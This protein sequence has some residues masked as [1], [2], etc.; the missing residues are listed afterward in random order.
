M[1]KN[2]TPKASRS[3]AALWKA[4]STSQR[5]CLRVYRSVCKLTLEGGLWLI[6]IFNLVET[7]NTAPIT[8]NV[9]FTTVKF[10]K[11]KAT[12]RT[13]KDNVITFLRH[14]IGIRA[15]T[16][17]LIQKNTKDEYSEK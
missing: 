12:I 9:I 10:L 4:P 17:L 11:S 5:K 7:I 15:L 8:G 6:N 2:F 14:Y 1:A 16:E 3:L 13:T